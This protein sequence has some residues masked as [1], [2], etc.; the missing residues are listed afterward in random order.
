M[1]TSLPTSEFAGLT[2]VLVEIDRVVPYWRNPRQITDE[3]VDAVA[4][5]IDRYGYQQPVV[6]DPSFV[7][8]I[9]HTR[10]QA[11]RRLGHTHLPVVVTTLPPEKVKQLRVLD[12]KVREYTSWDAEPL[13]DELADLDHQLMRAFFPEVAALEDPPPPDLPPPPPPSASAELVCPACFHMWTMEV[14]RA[15]LMR[16]LLRV[17]RVPSEVVG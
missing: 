11:L 17:P 16:G 13:M 2:P 7:I 12:N 5:S 3:A 15:D 1:S 9:G 6:V 4:A 14:T 8:V 10:Y